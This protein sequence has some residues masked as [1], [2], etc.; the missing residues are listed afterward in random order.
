MHYPNHNILIFNPNEEVNNNPP[1][2]NST[3]CTSLLYGLIFGSLGTLLLWLK[4]P[5]VREY[6]KSCYQ[7]INSESILNF[8]KCFL[9]VVIEIRQKNFIN[10]V[11]YKPF[12][13]FLFFS[14]FPNFSIFFYLAITTITYY[15]NFFPRDKKNTNFLSLRASYC[16]FL[17]LFGE[18]AH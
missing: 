7:N 15:E 10:V 5:K 14:I 12:G 17:L 8:F 11:L 6:L 13:I 3:L 16:S 2:K 9:Q 1:T 18:K 4:N